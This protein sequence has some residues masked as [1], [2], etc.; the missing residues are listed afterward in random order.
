LATIHLAVL[1][2][3]GKASEILVQ[4]ADI[5]RLMEMLLAAVSSSKA[6]EGSVHVERK[7]GCSK[8]GFVSIEPILR[9]N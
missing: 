6:I 4:N 8:N 3:N 5:K 7:K 9:I 2:V 1:S